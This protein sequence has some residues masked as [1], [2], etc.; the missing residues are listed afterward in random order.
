[1]ARGHVRKRGK[2]WV[3]VVPRDRDPETGTWRYAWGR[4][5]GTEREA[6][7]EV[8]RMLGRLDKGDDP[9]PERITVAAYAEKF[10]AHRAKLAE[11]GKPRPNHVR[12]SGTAAPRRG[13][14]AH[15]H[16]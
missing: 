5:V 6:W 3:P 16:A 8:R 11:S 15:R 14:A 12:K 2:G 7:A 10:F 1:M 4:Q 9:Y 13:V